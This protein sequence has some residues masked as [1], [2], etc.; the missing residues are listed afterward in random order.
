MTMSR[1]SALS[2][3]AG[4]LLAGCASAEVSDYQ[5]YDGPL[6]RPDRIL[7]YDPVIT[8]ADLPP[9]LAVLGNG[10]SAAPQSKEQLA[11]GRHLGAEIAKDLVSGMQDMGL[12][13]VAAA[14]QPAPR[15]GDILIAGYFTTV[16]AGNVAERV[17]VGF[18]EGGADLQTVV[19]GYLK[20]AGGLRPLGSGKVNAESG[21]MP[22][23]AVPLAVAVATANPI[24]LVVGGGVKAYGELSG[25]DTIEGAA[26]R[27]ANVV[28]EKIKAAAENRGWI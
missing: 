25:S 23:G 20:T 18:G 27:T 10:L 22:G 6:A 24:G 1:R 28:L 19:R 17:V 16:N 26:Q 21:K 4:A 8:P 11:L 7:V 2:L 3:L 12:P 15:P 9:E 5:P 13:A 14:G